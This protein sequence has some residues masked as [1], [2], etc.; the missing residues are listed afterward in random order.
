[1]IPVLDGGMILILMIQF[2]CRA[3]LPAAVT[4]GLTGLHEMAVWQT[5]WESRLLSG[6]ILKGVYIFLKQ[7]LKK[8]SR[9]SDISVWQKKRT[10]NA[11]NAAR[12]N[13]I[14]PLYGRHLNSWSCRPHR[15]FITYWCYCFVIDWSPIKGARIPRE[16]QSLSGRRETAPGPLMV[17]HDGV[18]PDTHLLRVLWYKQ[19]RCDPNSRLETLQTGDVL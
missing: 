2:I 14:Q 19:H 16:F 9:D 5:Q 1:M 13:L 12:L 11:W 18:N 17:V 3:G 6:W 10:E 7:C 15:F 4:E 8:L